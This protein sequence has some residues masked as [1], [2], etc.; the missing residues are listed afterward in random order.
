MNNISINQSNQS[1]QSNADILIFLN[2][3]LMNIDLAND[4]LNRFIDISKL[5]SIDMMAILDTFNKTNY[6]VNLTELQVVARFT[7]AF[8]NF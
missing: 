8:N 5:Y 1:N 7:E 4:A 3:K 2:S 6:D